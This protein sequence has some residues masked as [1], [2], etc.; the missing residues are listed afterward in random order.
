MSLWNNIV[1]FTGFSLFNKT[2]KLSGLSWSQL[3]DVLNLAKKNNMI[4]YIM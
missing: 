4:K 2:F 1:I 3:I